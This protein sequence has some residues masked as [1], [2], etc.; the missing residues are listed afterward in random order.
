MSTAHKSSEEV[1]DQES[2]QSNITPDAEHHMGMWQKHKKTS[3]TRQPRDQPFRG[4]EQTKLEGL[5]VYDGY[6]LTKN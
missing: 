5:N 2:I 6:N 4:K 3:P 1:K